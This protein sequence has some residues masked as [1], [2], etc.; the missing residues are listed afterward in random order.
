VLVVALGTQRSG[1]FTLC[2]HFALFLVCMGEGPQHAFVIPP[3]AT[4]WAVCGYRV[5]GGG[6]AQAPLRAVKAGFAI[7]HAL[8]RVAP[9][10]LRRQRAGQVIISVAWANQRRK[11]RAWIRR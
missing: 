9:A 6:R 3:V 11:K 2:S 10:G 5:P 4:G 7:M 1:E 8:L